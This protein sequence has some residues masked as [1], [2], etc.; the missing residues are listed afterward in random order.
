MKY[1]SDETKL[2][3]NT[4]EDLIAA[5]KAV[6][7][8]KQKQEQLKKEKSTRAKEVED[9]FKAVDEAQKHAYELLNA[10]TK[11]YGSFHMTWSDKNKRPVHPLFD[12]FF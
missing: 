3:Y 7:I 10:F 11:D 8:Q 5:E 12:I 1:Y 6:A 9:A 4:E 2:L